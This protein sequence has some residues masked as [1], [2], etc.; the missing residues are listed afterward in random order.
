MIDAKPAEGVEVSL[1]WSHETHSYIARK[2]ESDGSF[3]DYDLLHYD[4]TIKIV[5]PD[6]CFYEDKMTLDHSPAT[7]GLLD[8]YLDVKRG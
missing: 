2:Y 5:D 6:A 7:L 1:I 8:R 3:K 4:M